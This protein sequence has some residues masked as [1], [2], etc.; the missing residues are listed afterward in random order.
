[1][2][3]RD[4]WI[5]LKAASELALGKQENNN[6][7]YG[8]DQTLIEAFDAPEQSALDNNMSYVNSL[9]E[10]TD[11]NV[12]FALIPGQERD[13]VRHAAQSA[14]P[15]T[16]KQNSSTTA[17]VCQ[18]QTMWMCSALCREHAD[19]Y[20]YYRT[21]H[22]WTSLGAYYGFT[23]LGAGYGLGRSNS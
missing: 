10:N 23:A 2:Y 9:V 19:E 7:S 1:M 17:M 22:H 16:A 13:M 14:R 4:E 3:W 20:I 11:A 6:V 5:T 12:Y 8:K 18:M 15:T 21:D